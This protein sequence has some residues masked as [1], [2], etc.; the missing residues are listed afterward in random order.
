MGMPLLKE[1]PVS[2]L[3]IGVGEAFFTGLFRLIATLIF[4]FDKSFGTLT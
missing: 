2:R 3:A 1:N 4:I